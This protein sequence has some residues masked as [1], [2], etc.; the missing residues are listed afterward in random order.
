M[1]RLSLP[2][3][4]VVA[5]LAGLLML[6]VS[7]LAVGQTA[8]DC[9]QLDGTI[10]GQLDPQVLTTT[11]TID[12]PSSLVDGASTMFEVS[13][14]AVAA[15]GLSGIPD[16]TV[17]YVGEITVTANDGTLT[18]RDLGVFEVTGEFASVSKATDG[19]GL[20]AGSSGT[21]FFHGALTGPPGPDGTIPFEAPFTGELCLVDD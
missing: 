2:R 11:G 10:T 15:G 12:S 6:A 18:L 9:D 13:D 1:K 21:F 16:Q 14:F 17:S 20:F 3:Y 4:V 8:D 19:S 7:A 5:A